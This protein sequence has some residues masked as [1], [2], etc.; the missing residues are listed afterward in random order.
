MDAELVIVI[1]LGLLVMV[2][3][4]LGWYLHKRQ[5]HEV[6]DGA[7]SA[8]GDKGNE[9]KGAKQARATTREVVAT[10]GA[11]EL[12]REGK[13][14]DAARLAMRGQNWD[15]AKEYYLEAGQIS[16]A[17][18]C[19]HRAGKLEEAADLYEQCEDLENA[20][21]MWEKVGD[22]DRARE[23]RKVG[24]ETRQAPKVDSGDGKEDSGR[25]GAVPTTKQKKNIQASLDS[26]DYES[27]ARLAEEIGQDE[28][29][30]EAWVKVARRSK[31]PGEFAERI[32]KLS[33][34]VAHRF[35]ELETR[36]HPP[37]EK[38]APLHYRLA[39]SYARLGDPA[40]AI[41]VLKRL[42]RAVGSYEDAASLV[43]ELATH[44]H[45]HVLLLS[46]AMVQEAKAGLSIEQL[47]DMIGGA[48]CD[49]TN[50][51]VFYRLGLARLA[52][53]GWSEAEAAFRTVESTSPGYRDAAARLKL[54]RTLGSR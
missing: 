44:P 28:Q 34:T 51:E 39:R 12:M 50:I 49:M 9:P 46:D 42:L 45:R 33:P 10:L 11:E 36:A 53:E 13:Y 21:K 17:A 6:E 31:N 52:T 26:G 15:E 54:L 19:A 3:L 40:S 43:E 48:S 47:Q 37:S 7:L 30:A 18:H 29:A 2:G 27:A 32:E 41:D 16:N 14:E 5:Q 1:G 22:H 8:R 20:A 25:H 24:H 35:L 38:S 23:L 4:G